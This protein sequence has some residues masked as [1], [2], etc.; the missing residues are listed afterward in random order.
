MASVTKKLEN[1]VKAL[2]KGQLK[3]ALYS[4]DHEKT[5]RQHQSVERAARTCLANRSDKEACKGAMKKARDEIQETISAP[6]DDTSLEGM[7]EYL[8][9]SQPQAEAPVEAPAGPTDEELYEECQE[10]HI[11]VAATQFAQACGSDPE[12]GI[13]KLI[14]ERLD[15]E[16][17]EP[18][19]WLK[20]MTET[21]E[22]AEGEQ[23]EKM[24]A[25]LSELTEYL[26]RKDSP[27][28]KE[29]DNG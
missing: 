24:T 19:H 17:T 11:A 4:T 16:T 12:G 20:V 25:A 15:D 5:Q 26:R 3:K 9:P 21:A 7:D 1:A 14:S 29:M 6:I 13:C 28:L 2:D 27:F 23:K 22:K 18:A 10:C 8:P